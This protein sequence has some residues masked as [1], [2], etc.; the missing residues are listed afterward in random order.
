MRTPFWDAGQQADYRRQQD[1]AVTRR[2]DTREG[3]AAAQEI[4]ALWSSLG[5]DERAVMQQLVLCAAPSC[6]GSCDDPLLSALVDKG[7]LSWPPGVRP[8]LHSDLVTSFLV[9]PAVWNALNARREMVIPA[10]LDRGAFDADIAQRFGNRFMPI[11]PA[12][13][14]EPDFPPL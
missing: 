7:M 12:A 6:I 8:V 10:A 14:A 1:A 13:S 5:D 11:A 4:D 2:S 9:P 3:V